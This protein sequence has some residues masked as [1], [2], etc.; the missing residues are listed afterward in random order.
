MLTCAFAFADGEQQLSFVFNDVP[1]VQTK[2]AVSS[3]WETASNSQHSK[4]IVKAEKYE[5]HD[6]LTRSLGFQFP[7][8]DSMPTLAF[9]KI[10]PS[11]GTAAGVFDQGLFSYFLYRN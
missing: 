8:S 4:A 7:N 5:D 10:M 2:P 1:L 3:I 6:G 9:N 11:K